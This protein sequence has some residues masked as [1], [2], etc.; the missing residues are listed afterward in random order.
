MFILAKSIKGQEYMYD[1]R[2]AH[3][4]S[5]ASKKSIC[6]TLNEIR[7]CLRD[8]EVWHAHEVFEIDRGY[9]YGLYQKFYIKNGSLK[10]ARI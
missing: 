9:D 3:K 6:D 10:E 1:V 5:K 8:N 2:T 4:V 7:Y